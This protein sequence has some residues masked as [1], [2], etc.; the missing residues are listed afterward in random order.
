MYKIMMLA[1]AV[2]LLAACNSADSDKTSETTTEDA[3]GAKTEWTNLFDGAST[4]GWHQYGK[5]GVTP[6]W[7]IADSAVY[8]DTSVKNSEADLITDE[9]F[10]NFDLKLEWMIAK[11]GNSGIVFCI[12]EETTKYKEPY[13]TGPE[14]QVLDNEGHDDGK[15]P[16]HRAGD[17][18]DLISCSKETVK[19]AGEWNKVEIKCLNGKLDFFLNGEN[20]VSTTM[21]DDNWRKLI[22]GSKFK[23]WPGFG[24]YKKGSISLQDHHNM[25]SYKNI[26]IKKL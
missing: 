21:W 23:D 16:K 15:Y 24:T 4:A 26:K 17:L 6:R 1:S 5:Q 18:Y 8:V 3:M 10:E 14:M 22:A 7:K 13:D 25:V 2:F 11:G 9:E 19:P 12:H 20:V